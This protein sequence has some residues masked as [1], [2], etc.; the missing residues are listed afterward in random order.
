MKLLSLEDGVWPSDTHAMQHADNLIC[1]SFVLVYDA[2]WNKNYLLG[3]QYI[4][5][6]TH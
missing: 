1:F 4:V 2:L 3:L 5:S 6:N